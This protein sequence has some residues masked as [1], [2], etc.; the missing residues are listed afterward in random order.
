MD[1]KREIL[2]NVL[3]VL[4]NDILSIE[5]KALREGKFNNLSISELHV[6]EAVGLKEPVNM[7]K[8]A[9]HLKVTTGTL[10]I[11]INRLVRKE[12]VKR[13]RDYEDKRVVNL[14]LSELGHEAFNHHEKFHDEM[15]ECIMTD[16]TKEEGDVLVKALSKIVIYFEDKYNTKIAESR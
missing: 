2:N 16:L 11:A 5:E 8:V 7:T 6:I 10:T 15:I 14:S 3:V 1:N 4:F 9:N 13:E 12:Y